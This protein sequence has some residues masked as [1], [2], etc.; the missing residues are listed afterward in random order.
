[1]N[2]LERVVA[3]LGH[4]EADRVPVYPILSGVTRNLVGASYKTWAN[5]ADVCTAA[6]VKAAK[7]YDLD[8]LV[9]LIDLSIECDAWGQELIFPENEAAHPNY[10]NCLLNS[11]DDYDK[12]KKVDYRTSKRMMMHIDV[13]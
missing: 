9:T 11:I 4:K 2:S 12:V 6:Y 8:C 5:D 7:E 3:C 1:M 13:W 10:N